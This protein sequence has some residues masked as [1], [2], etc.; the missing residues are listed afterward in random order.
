MPDVASF[1]NNAQILSLCVL[2]YVKFF[3]RITNFSG[4][5]NVFSKTGVRAMLYPCAEIDLK[6]LMW[7]YCGYLDVSNCCYNVKQSMV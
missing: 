6:N 5:L 7:I 3:L 2:G 4:C 1:A